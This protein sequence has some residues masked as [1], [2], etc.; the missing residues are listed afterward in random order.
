MCSLAGT[1]QKT[2]KTLGISFKS[3]L[4]QG[5]LALA[6]RRHP[7]ADAGGTD[8][9]ASAT[10]TPVPSQEMPRKAM[11]VHASVSKHV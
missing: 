7:T 4:V 9:K 6:E 3:R 5:P 10:S 1:A 2:N 11:W 8:L